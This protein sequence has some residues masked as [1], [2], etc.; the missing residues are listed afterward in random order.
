M[1]ILIGT[2]IH[3]VKEYGIYEWLDSVS[4][5]DWSDYFL[6]LV[7]NSP[8]RDFPER[9]KRYCQ[10]LGLNFR[11]VHLERAGDKDVEERLAL[12]REVIREEIIKGGYDVWFSWECDI[13]LPPD[14]LKILLPYLFVFDIVNHMYPD[15][16][17]PN[18]E[19]GGIGC[20]LYKAEIIKKLSFLGG[21]GQCDPVVPNCY[22]SGDSY[23]VTRALRMKYKMVDFHNLMEVK[24]LCHK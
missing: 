16:D 18:I 10:E 14:A 19:V 8:S 5:L 4:K 13:L 21:Y 20:S 15:R 3:E 7:D 12:S 24:H 1:K 2:P 9:V 11:L 6:L 17:D 23:L 22:Y